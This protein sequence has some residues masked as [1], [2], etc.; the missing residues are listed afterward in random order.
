MKDTPEV[1]E[2]LQSAMVKG[3]EAQDTL[4]RL[5]PLFVALREQYRASLVYSVRQ[6][7]SEKEIAM[8][9]CR[10]AALEDLYESIY[11]DAVTGSRAHKAATELES[12]TH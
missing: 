7:A 10:I 5:D 3:V 9:A 11:Q 6:K 12:G 2:R 1:R 4:K 8:D